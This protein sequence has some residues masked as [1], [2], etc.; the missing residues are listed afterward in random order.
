MIAR[1]WS[2]RV[3]K[4]NNNLYLNHFSNAVLPELCK[5]DGYVSSTVL[6]RFAGDTTEILVTTVWRSFESID[7]FAS[8]DREAAVV[9]PEAA[10]LLL[11]Y[12]RRVK[13]FEIAVSDSR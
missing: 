1:L 10:A 2:A 11:D 6:T 7:A 13:H 8:R 12:D 3:T 5:L 4:A 9:A